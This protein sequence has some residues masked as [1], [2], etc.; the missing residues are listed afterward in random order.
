MFRMTIDTRIVY[1]PTPYYLYY[2]FGA[3]TGQ[4]MIQLPLKLY[5]PGIPGNDY[6]FNGTIYWG[7]GTSD[8]LGY[9]YRNHTYTT[10][11]IYQ[12]SIKVNSGGSLAIFDSGSL[13]N[14]RLKILSIDEWGDMGANPSY[15]YDVSFN[16]CHN[17]SLSATTDTPKFINAYNIQSLFA[18]TFTGETSINNIGTWDVRPVEYMDNF[19]FDPDNFG[20]KLKTSNYN[21]LLIGWASYGTLLQN[22]VISDFNLSKFSGV[23]ATNSKNYLSTTKGWVITDGGPV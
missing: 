20:G 19:M 16:G 17:L 7:D 8:P 14:D 2:T 4:N 21:S 23:T 5:N 10:P 15:V 1:G 13:R 22:G 9:I 12:I 11:G 6:S 18:N 3:S